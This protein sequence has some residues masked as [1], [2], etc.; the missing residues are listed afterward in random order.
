MS[1]A[2]LCGYIE[3][4]FH[5]HFDLVGFINVVKT[6]IKENNI[7]K[8]YHCNRTYFDTK[9]CDLVSF[10][11]F[12]SV[13]IIELKDIYKKDYDYRLRNNKRADMIFCPFEEEIDNSVLYK[14]FY[15]WA[16][17]NSDILITYSKFDDDISQRIIK[18]TSAKGKKV[19]NIAEMLKED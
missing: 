18:K 3:E 16:I 4:G 9:F 10:W 11:G 17:D 2:F 8:I 13:E 1:T 5:K 12:D 14:T 15:D 19:I 7:E 6:I